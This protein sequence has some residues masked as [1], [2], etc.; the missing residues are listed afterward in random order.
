MLE[1]P[2]KETKFYYSIVPFKRQTESLIYNFPFLE[3]SNFGNPYDDT[4]PAFSSVQLT[5]YPV[6][7]NKGV[8]K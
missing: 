1:T 4:K 8:I 5:T 2:F 7:P 3:L 6:A